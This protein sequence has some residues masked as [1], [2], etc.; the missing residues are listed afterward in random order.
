MK[1]WEI[2][3]FVFLASIF[4]RIEISADHP[5]VQFHTTASIT[6]SCPND[7]NTIETHLT[8]LQT[9]Y[10]GR[11]SQF[12]EGDSYCWIPGYGYQYSFLLHY[13]FHSEKICGHTVHCQSDLL[14]SADRYIYAYR[15][16]II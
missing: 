14:R 1:R 3:I 9:L 13:Y 10:E 6:A 2:L 4:V 11:V 5:G 15:K 7:F 8:P 16:I 12:S